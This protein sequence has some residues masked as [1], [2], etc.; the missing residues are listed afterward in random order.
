VKS[1]P[2]FWRFVVL[3]LSFGITKKCDCSLVYI[4]LPNIVTIS[5]HTYDS[6]VE[7]P[8]LTLSL[9]AICSV[10]PNEKKKEKREKEFF[11]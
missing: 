5:Q 10:N 9:V 8:V 4:N 11:F 3:S 1:F 7:V 6:V 2:L